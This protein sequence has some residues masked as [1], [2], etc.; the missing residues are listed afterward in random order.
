MGVDMRIIPTNKSIAGIIQTEIDQKTKPLGSLG[1]VETLAL[2]LGVI[3]QT[4][5]P[6]IS[7]PVVFICAGNHGITQKGVSAYPA[8][9]TAQMLLNF[10]NGGAAI[11][12]LAKS[13]GLQVEI[14]NA[15][16]DVSTIENLVNLNLP[17]ANST[18]DFSSQDAM[19]SIQCEAAIA[20]GHERATACIENGT[21]FVLLGEM[22][23]GNTSAAA[24]IT[25]IMTGFPIDICVG[26]GTGLGDQALKEKQQVLGAAIEFHGR[27]HEPLTVLRK[28]GGLE[29]AALVGIIFAAA[30]NGCAI[31]VDGYI[32]TSAALI[33]V[34]LQPNV[35]DYLIFSHLSKEPGHRIALDHL[36]GTAIL[37]LDLCLGEGSGAA[38]AFPIVKAAS[39]I[40]SDMATFESASVSTVRSEV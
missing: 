32:T 17:I 6:R 24:V 19:T 8:E 31:L 27:E 25:S 38:L 30:Q 5:T 39:E 21:N 18:Q 37:S 34:A 36:A 3:Y 22:G 7:K 4:K 11:N 40:L 13:F 35:S 29:I 1:V 33:A 15:G 2:Q 23:I 20:L 16:V 10:K 26:R 9:V 28:F 14:V 12:V